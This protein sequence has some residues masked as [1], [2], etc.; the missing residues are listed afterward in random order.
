MNLNSHGS[1]ES[2]SD[3]QTD[4]SVNQD[5]TE[6]LYRNGP[7]WNS[8]RS[9]RNRVIAGFFVALPIIVTFI[10]IRWLYNFIAR[11]I[12]TT[13]ATWIIQLWRPAIEDAKIEIPQFVEYILAPVVA[14]GVILGALFLLGMLIQSRTLQLVDWVLQSVPGV[15]IIY[16]SVRNAI[17]SMRKTSG[18]KQ[19]FKRVVLV[20]FPH[21]GMKVPAFVTS[22]TK[23]ATTGENILCVYVPTTPIPT[24]GYMLMIPESEVTEISWDLSETL[25]A[26]VSGGMTVPEVVE[27]HDNKILNAKL[28]D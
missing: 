3:D 27:Y 4:S 15:G 6:T 24:S 10:V 21:P 23:D 19:N 28:K 5:S 9:V 1:S 13:M 22:S 17:N 26:I 12:I 25:Q 2:Q 8:F 20:K 11:D 14:V 16:S 7:F 18:Q